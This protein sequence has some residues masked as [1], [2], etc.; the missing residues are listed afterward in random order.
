MLAIKKKTILIIIA[1][2]VGIVVSVTGVVQFLT[3]VGDEKIRKYNEVLSDSLNENIHFMLEIKVPHLSEEPRRYMEHY[4]YEE[5]R[6]RISTYPQEKE[7]ME[8]HELVYEGVDYNYSV[9]GDDAEVHVSNYVMPIDGI[10]DTLDSTYYSIN[11]ANVTYEETDSQ[12]IFTYVNKWR[13]NTEVWDDYHE[14][15]E[16]GYTSGISVAYID[17]E[18]NLEKLVVTETWNVLDENGEEVERERTI[19]LTY[20]DTSD[21]EIQKALKTEYDMLMVELYGE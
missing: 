14:E 19:T 2:T 21:E 17:K 7:K 3:N 12:Y 20:Y 5:N 9:R 6:L 13:N 4:K 8:S 1:I 18:W 10:P 11:G 16:G 15:V